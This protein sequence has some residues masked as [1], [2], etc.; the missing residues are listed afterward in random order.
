MLYNEKYGN[1]RKQD[2]PHICMCTVTD[3]ICRAVH[4]VWMCEIL[5]LDVETVFELQ[6]KLGS[7]SKERKCELEVKQ[8]ILN[9]CT[10]CV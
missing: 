2:F 5:L 8:N 9:A 1:A 7:P 6:T 4:R 10:E 3:V